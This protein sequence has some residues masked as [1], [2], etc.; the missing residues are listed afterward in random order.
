LSELSGKLTYFDQPACPA[1]I[2]IIAY[3]RHQRL[4]RA[5]LALLACWGL[6]A[7]AILIPILHF[8]LVPALFLAGPFFAYRRLHEEATVTHIRGAC[9]ACGKPIDHGG[10]EPWKALLRLDCEHCHRRIVLE[11]SLR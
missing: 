10:R 8:L 4:V 5:V 11:A 3:D 7:L 2:E 9:P 6:A 1:T